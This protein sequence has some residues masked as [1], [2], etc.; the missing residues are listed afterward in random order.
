MRVD[1]YLK[2]SR[3]IKRRTIAKEVCDRGL[4]R[5]NGRAAKA[6]TDVKPGDI[7]EISLGRRRLKVEVCM[8]AESMSS[9]LVSQMYKV[10]EDRKIGN[11]QEDY[12]Q[13]P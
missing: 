13:G 12:L 1:K 5:I 3:L 6:G 11:E 10:I 8:L 9:K 4:V 2:V 7:I